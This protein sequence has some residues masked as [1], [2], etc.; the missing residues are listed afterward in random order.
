MTKYI[1]LSLV[2][3]VLIFLTACTAGDTQTGENGSIIIAGSTT[4]TP[5]M[6]ELQEV[7][8]SQTG[9]TVEVQEIGTSAGINATIDGISNIAMASRSM[10]EGEIERGIQPVPIALDGVAIIVHYTN[11]VDN[12]TLDQIEAIF[13]GEIN[14]WSQVGGENRAITVVSRELGSGIRSSFETFSGVRDQFHINGHDVW[15]SGVY[16]HALISSGTGGVLNSVSS[17]R[18]AVGYITTGIENALI[19]SVAVDG[20]R[21]SAQTAQDGTYPFSN[22]FYLGIMDDLTP[23]S[24]TFIDWV[25]SEQGQFA[26]ADAEFVPIN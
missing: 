1:K 5:L 19:R 16:P 21:F 9:I 20:V 7:F 22:V 17:N 26:V 25:L 12:L 24:R 3:T 2:V 14:N 18:G 10:T 11:P 23:A 6:R 13:R 8:M 4:V 15:I